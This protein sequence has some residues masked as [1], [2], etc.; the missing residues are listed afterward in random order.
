[1][2]IIQ[3]DERRGL[4]DPDELDV[5]DDDDLY[6][7]MVAFFNLEGDEQ[8]ERRG[9]NY[10]AS[11]EFWSE[12]DGFLPSMSIESLQDINGLKILQCASI[13]IESVMLAIQLSCWNK[14]S[15][16]Q[17][18]HERCSQ[19]GRDDNKGV[20]RDAEGDADVS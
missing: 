9:L 15:C 2:K 18:N 10:L 3:Q 1:M 17:G 19:A 11:V 12:G 20:F 8:D 6:L 7:Q 16:E 13:V 4:N 14:S 5:E